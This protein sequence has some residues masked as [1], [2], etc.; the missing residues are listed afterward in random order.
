LIANEKELFAGRYLL[1]ADVYPLLAVIRYICNKYAVMETIPAASQAR[2]TRK[3]PEY[4]IYE[5]MDGQPI[6]RKGYKSVLNKTKTLEDIM[7]SSTLQGEVHLYVLSL[8]LQYFGLE[9][10]TIHCNEA[11]LHIGKGNNLA[12][13]IFVYDARVMTGAKIG[14]HYSDVPPLLAF[15]IDIEA[16]LEAMTEMGYVSRKIEK[17]L[18]FGVKKVFWISTEAQ[19]VLIAEA[20]RD[21]PTVSWEKDIEIVPGLS[22]NILDHLQ[23]RGIFLEK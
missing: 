12:G 18:R 23:K 14:K 3:I 9:K 5:V 6:Y 10:F 1:S 11:G 8:L 19:R 22:M 2:K 20:G 21:W 13:D 7:G 17:L 16:D 4:L 15:E